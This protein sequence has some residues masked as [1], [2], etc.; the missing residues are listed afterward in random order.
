[1]LAR[2]SALSPPGEDPP[3]PIWLPGVAGQRGVPGPAAALPV[4]PRGLLAVSVASWSLP[5]SG[6][7]VTGRRPSLLLCDLTVT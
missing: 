6:A 3:L 1:M 5:L 4:L 7:A 2:S